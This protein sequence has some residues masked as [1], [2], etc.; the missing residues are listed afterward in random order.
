VRRAGDAPGSLDPCDVVPL[1]ASATAAQKVQ[2]FL[3]ACPPR[4]PGSSVPPYAWTR[5]SPPSLGQRDSNPRRW[6]TTARLVLPS[7]DN[8]PSGRAVGAA[9]VAE[10]A[11]AMSEDLRA[12]TR[13]CAR[14]RSARPPKSRARVCCARAR[15]RRS[16]RGLRRLRD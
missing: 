12:P 8:V 9:R 2:V 7:P 6:L 11:E 14:M 5:H 4:V 15:R 10:S 13:L 1:H 16:S 3:T